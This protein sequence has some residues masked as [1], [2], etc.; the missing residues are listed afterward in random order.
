[1]LHLVV[2]QFS[3]IFLTGIKCQVSQSV[4]LVVVGKNQYVLR[5]QQINRY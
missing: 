5:V 1:M 3:V 4:K 2:H